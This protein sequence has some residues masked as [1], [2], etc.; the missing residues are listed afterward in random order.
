MSKTTK[1]LIKLS[2]ILLLS[3]FFIY[4]ASVILTDLIKKGSGVHSGLGLLNNQLVIPIIVFSFINIFILQIKFFREYK[5]LFKRIFRMDLLIT[6]ASHI[7]FLYALINLIINQVQNNPILEYHF[8]DVNIV[9]FLFFTI[10][11]FL[12]NK[13]KQKNTINIR[14]LL[15]FLNKESTIIKNN[16]KIKVQR[17]AIKKDD[18]VLISKGE[19]ICVDGYLIDP[20]ASLDYS[21][22]NGEFMP[23]TLNKDEVVLSGAVNLGETIKIKAKSDV[24]DSRLVNVIKNLEKI[25]QSKTK[26]EVLS[27]KITR[28]FIPSVLLLSLVT[29]IIWL[30]SVYLA[31]PDFSNTIYQKIFGS[32]RNN[33]WSIAIWVG[34]SILVIAC[35]CAF[36]IATPIAIYIASAVATQNKI[37]FANAAVYERALKLKYIA[38]DKTGTLTTGKI[39]ITNFFGDQE[40]L[41]F[42]KSLAQLS[43]HP[44]SNAINSYIENKQH[45]SLE[46]VKE[47]PGIGMFAVYQNKEYFLGSLNYA[48]KTNK[49]NQI[50]FEQKESSSYVVLCED[51]KVVNLFEITDQLKDGVRE[52]LKFLAKNKIKPLILS[53]DDIVHVRHIAEKLGIRDYYANLLPE[54][55]A[56]IIEK[57]QKNNQ[58]VGYVGDGINDILASKKAHISFSFAT[59]S[60]LNN[61]LSDITLNENDLNLIPKAIFLIKKTLKTVKLNF[62]WAVLFNFLAIPLAISGIIF[63]EVGVFAMFASSFLVLFNTIFFK[64][65]T[66]KQLKK[67]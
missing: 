37:F 29:A 30:I 42:A 55:K 46:N 23:K 11:S 14:E 61:S 66:K 43:T 48:I 40:K 56:N 8:W 16:E 59:G 12:E 38:F 33:P 32:Q 7:T 24:N 21:Q 27:Q 60:D 3:L 15:F 5:L 62:L 47:I 28:W 4:T 34:V 54:D 64:Y 65:R 9:L 63:P 35:P 53:G 49:I 57:Y 2:V 13:L 20:V 1:N 58:E 41:I 52:V 17:R 50:Q 10:G 19:M 25:V 51:N 26:I 6:L 31:Q 44:I 22:I 45:L 67:I 36:A 39:K 18:L